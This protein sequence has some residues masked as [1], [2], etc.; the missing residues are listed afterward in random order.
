MNLS[1]SEEQKIIVNSIKSNHNIIVD[2]V[3]GAGKTT[4]IL[5]AAIENPDL[6]ILL[7]TYNRSLCI[8]VRDKIS[9]YNVKNVEVHTY[10]S[11]AV[12]YYNPNTFTDHVLNNVIAD[13][14]PPRRPLYK[15]DYIF[16]DEVQDMT[17]LLYTF[18]RKIICDLNYRPRLAILGD[19][20][21]GIY[22]YKGADTRFITQASNLW[23]DFGK[24]TY[25][26]LHQSFRV[27]KNIAWFLNVVM[28]GETRI[29]SNKIVN[30]YKIQ[31]FRDTDYNIGVKLFAYIQYIIEIKKYKPD[32][33]FVL[34]PT[35]K[36]GKYKEL[37]NRLCKNK[38][39]CFVPIND[40]KNIDAEI[41]NSKI[42]FT[43]FHQSKGLERKV[44]IIVN[45][46]SSY[47][48]K[49]VN[50]LECP[51]TLYVGVTRACER[52]V[53]CET[54][55]NDSLQFLKKSHTQM[56]IN[57]K[58]KYEGSPRLE[59]SIKVEDRHTD[60]NVIFP[61]VIINHVN[62]KY[63]NELNTLLS[64]IYTKE[65]GVEYKLYIPKSHNKEDVSDINAIVIPSIIE[66]EYTGK[67][68]MY[69][70]ITTHKHNP[71]YNKY[72]KK[73][74]YPCR[75]IQDYLYLSNVYISI[76]SG[77]LHKLEQ[78]RTYDWMNDTIINTTTDYLKDHILP[79]CE[80]EMVL[81]EDYM[82][83]QSHKKCHKS[84]H[85]KYGELNYCSRI[86]AIDNKNI[87][88]FKCV[89]TIRQEHKYQLVI[90]AWIWNNCMKKK[91]GKRRFKLL[92]LYTGEIFKL[93][94]NKKT[95]DS[96]NRIVEILLENRFLQTD[97]L[98][99]RKFIKEM[100]KRYRKKFRLA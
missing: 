36:Y 26:S 7:F 5:F 75:T 97:E 37:E 87:Y 66:Y 70:Y 61:S 62:Y 84:V 56:I 46:D 54:F 55:N 76:E 27:T 93:H 23:K 78:I 74:K 72:I 68:F 42:V 89:E 20:K 22:K 77:T 65:K 80:F 38:Y 96:I 10:H 49:I 69:D 32:D 30:N 50:K 81:G 67:N 2:A 34:V 21:Q 40:E 44:V 29:I 83:E 51:P 4:T 94:Y 90:Y 60:N 14:I 92:N 91:N 99:D 58:I 48:K 53:L 52:L 31:Y 11:F 6:K 16:M 100:R 39:K 88:E 43:T 47:M 95:K 25:L 35:V 79:E 15:P 82:N 24:F 3:A 98:D 13:N 64:N 28:L 1:L 8:D 19:N 86:D 71:I 45:F 59:K 9:K 18:V 57:K 12:K 85:K 41:I 63:Q 33:I 17:E 73:I